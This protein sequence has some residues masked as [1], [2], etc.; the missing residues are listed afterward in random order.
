MAILVYIGVVLVTWVVSLKTPILYSR[1]FMT[2]TG[3]FIFFLA[4]SMSKSKYNYITG[5]LCGLILMISIFTSIDLIKTNYAEENSKP[6]EFISNSIQEGDV[7]LI[8][9]EL[10]GFVEAVNFPEYNTYFYDKNKWNSEEA[11]K[12]FGNNFKTIYDLK[13]MDNYSGKIWIID[14]SDY[15]LCDEIKEL[16]TDK[17]TIINQEKFDTKYHNY[18]Y[19]ITLVEKEV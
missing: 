6:M 19:A 11:Y 10:S 9:N 4:Y 17:I 3:L 2:V 7:I 14:A 1:Y 16:Y 12:G 5:I 8:K 13:E 15:S 18:Q